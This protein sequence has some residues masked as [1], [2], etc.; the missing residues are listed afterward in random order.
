MSITAD[1]QHSKHPMIGIMQPYFFPY[2][3]YF[4]L[5]H[6]V[7]TYVNL[8]HVAFMKRSY[9]TRNTLKNDTS[10]NVS[11]WGGSQNKQCA[12][13]LVNFSDN[14]IQNFE[15]KLHHLYSKAPH[16]RTICD[17]IMPEFYEREVSISAFNFNL[18]KRICGYL[19]IQ[20]TLIDSSTTFTDCHLPR[21]AGLKC[22]TKALGSTAYVNAIGGQAL[23]TKD[24][25]ICDGI[26]LYFVEMLEVDLDNKYA[27]ILDLLFRYDQ[28]HLRHQLT[29]YQL[30]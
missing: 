1:I 25:F 29:R 11:V 14:Y 16:Y 23:Y 10:I 30:I 21:E 19:E 24:D 3:G 8:D 5:I 20:T 17:L 12:E 9:M 13:V 15:A 18:I 6:A 7:D 27:S 22:I 28:L 4:Q 2:I 26:E